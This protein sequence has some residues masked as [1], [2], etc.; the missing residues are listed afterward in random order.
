MRYLERI[1]LLILL[2][3]MAACQTKYGP[4]GMTGGYRDKKL[5]EGRYIVSF[6]GNGNTPEQKVWN[7]WIYRCAELTSLSGYDYFELQPSDTHALHDTGE[8][9]YQFSMIPDNPF[10]TLRPGGPRTV[11]YTTITTYS[12]KAVV[13]M[14]RNP[15]PTTTKL[16]LDA[17]TIISVVKPYVDTD[18][19]TTVPERK[20]IL[21]RAAVEAAIKSNKIKQEDSNTLEGLLRKAL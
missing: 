13:Q 12:S 17:R 14:Y 2:V 9:P 15:V 20:D 7:F 16:L 4:N 5:G 6:F 1:L 21:L 8:Q 3:F 18:G 10:E 19:K 11:A